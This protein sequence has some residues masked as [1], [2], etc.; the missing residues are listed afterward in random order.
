MMKTLYKSILDADFDTDDVVVIPHIKDRIA[1]NMGRS[2]YKSCGHKI[3]IKVEKDTAIIN[4]SSRDKS[5]EVDITHKL[6]DEIL[7]LLKAK[8]LTLIFKR[9]NGTLS[10]YMLG[11][12]EGLTVEADNIF[13]YSSRSDFRAPGKDATQVRLKK[14]VI[15][16]HRLT[17][18]QTEL[19]VEKCKLN[20]DDVDMRACA[21][22]NVI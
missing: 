20:Y 14:S 21:C 7:K 2:D 9:K 11:D 22:I 5:V 17:M 8:Y 3:D 19:T 6:W 1:Q 10:L 13:M 12:W 15:N 18:H 4:I 16:T